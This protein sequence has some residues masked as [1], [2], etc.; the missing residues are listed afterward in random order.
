MDATVIS[1]ESSR[2]T[3]YD[4]GKIKIGLYYEP[5]KPPLEQDELLL[6][7]ALLGIVP[8]KETFFQRLIS[9][10]MKG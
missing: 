9:R 7:H 10:L 5:P 1:K 4:T 6:Q 2:T 8:P 3:P